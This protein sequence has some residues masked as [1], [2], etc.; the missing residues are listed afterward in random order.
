[1]PS[2][3]VSKYETPLFDVKDAMQAS[4]LQ[5]MRLIQ[6]VNPVSTQ[7]FFATAQSLPKEQGAL[8]FAAALVHISGFSQ[9]PPNR[10]L[11]TCKPV[12]VSENLIRPCN[13]LSAVSY[14]ETN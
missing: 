9:L 1:L 7:E 10:S 14:A 13:L 6:H 5:V 12:C 4:N 11:L 2:K 8:I 3:R